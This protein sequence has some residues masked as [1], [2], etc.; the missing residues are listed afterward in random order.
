MKVN[1]HSLC[2]LIGSSPD[3]AKMWDLR[4]ERALAVVREIGNIA[5]W[6]RNGCY[7]LKGVTS[8]E[9]RVDINHLSLF[10]RGEQEPPISDSEAIVPF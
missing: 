9:N 6:K 1:L 10:I 8:R 7:P 4:A 2:S 3:D 5:A